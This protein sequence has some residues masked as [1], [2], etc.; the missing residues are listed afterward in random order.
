MRQEKTGN[1][2]LYD[3]HLIGRTFIATATG[4]PGMEKEETQLRG[5]DWQNSRARP[6][7][8]NDACSYLPLGR[9]ST[10]K[11]YNSHT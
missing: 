5:T 9:S 4:L 10:T 11:Y 8:D 1:N 6:D 7:C 2:D 3:S